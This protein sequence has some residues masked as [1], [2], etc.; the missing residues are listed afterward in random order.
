M[1]KSQYILGGRK[2]GAKVGTWRKELSR[3]QK[4]AFSHQ[5]L[6]KEMSYRLTYRL[7]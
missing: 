2:A 6:I 5:S 7:I 3:D 1:S 4:D